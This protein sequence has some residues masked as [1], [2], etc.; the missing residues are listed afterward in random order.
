MRKLIATTLFLASLFFVAAEARAQGTPSLDSSEIDVAQRINAERVRLGLNPLQISLKLTEV[1]DWMNADMAAN[2]YFGHTD[3]LGRGA[4]AR[5][6][7]LGY[8]HNT[9]KG[10]ILAALQTSAAQV[11]TD[12]INSPSHYDAIKNP[13]YRVLGVSHLYAPGSQYGDY[14][15]VE[16]GGHTDTLMQADIGPVSY[17]T[18]VNA[19]SYQDGGAPGMLASVFGVFLN[20][21]GATDS[22]PTLPLPTSLLSLEVRVDGQSAGLIYVS[23]FQINFHVPAGVGTGTK[24]VDVYRAGSLVARG[25][26]NFAANFGGI[27]TAQA[28]G[29]GA[30]AGQLTDG[31]AYETLFDATGQPR[32]FKPGSDSKPTYL[33]LYGT[34]LTSLTAQTLQVYIHESVTDSY[35]PCDI[36][37]VGPQGQF[38]GLDQLNIK[39]PGVLSTIPGTKRIRMYVNGNFYGNTTEI[40]T[41]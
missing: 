4:T 5:L 38:V 17:A 31:G 39:L 28:S 11:V 2:R 30:P 26:L 36:A 12:W 23:N 20:G 25:N 3:S 1:A 33:V 6:N 24:M 29:Q 18:A 32:P 37:Y 27:F 35:Y 7:Q 16:F 21:S 19:A 34:G 22:A 15:A 9:A 8:S 40:T 10:E 13:K 41:Q 14:W